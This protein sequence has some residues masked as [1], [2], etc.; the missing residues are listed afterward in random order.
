MQ[1]A[2]ECVGLGVREGAGEAD[3]RASVRGGAR[4]SV[5]GPHSPAHLTSLGRIAA[6][7]LSETEREPCTPFY[8][9][10]GNSTC[11]YYAI[12]NSYSVATLHA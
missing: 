9:Y 1:W 7:V 11:M 4:A 8:M 3:A 2:T 5:R 12:V 6:S 10:Y